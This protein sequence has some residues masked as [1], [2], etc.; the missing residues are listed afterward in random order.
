M[1]QFRFEIGSK[2]KIVDAPFEFY[3]EALID[4]KSVWLLRE[5]RGGGQLRNFTLLELNAL[6]DQGRLVRDPEQN[7]HLPDGAA[8]EARRKVKIGELPKKGRNR[9][10]SRKKILNEVDRRIGSRGLETPVR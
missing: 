2:I 3:Q 9:F 7:L 1:A 5:R 10:N 4:M 8:I 6:Y